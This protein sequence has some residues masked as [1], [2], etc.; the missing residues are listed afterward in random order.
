MLLSAGSAHRDIAETLFVTIHTVAHHI[1]ATQ[2]RFGVNSRYALVAA[3]F[4]SGVLSDQIWPPCST[5]ILCTRIPAGS[6][7]AKNRGEKL[8][9]TRLLAPAPK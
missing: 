5:G 3:G 4:I 9:Y 1:T 2:E 6:S 7:E 8:A